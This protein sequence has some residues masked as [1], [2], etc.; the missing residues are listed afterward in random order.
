MRVFI[1]STHLDLKEYRAAAIRIL[2]NLN[3]EAIVGDDLVDSKY[4]PSEIVDICTKRAS[5]VDKLVLIIGIRQGWVPQQNEHGD[6]ENSI[7]LLEFIS[8][9]QSVG[10]DNLAIFVID[11]DYKVLLGQ[12]HDKPFPVSKEIEL[13]SEHV[14]SYFTN[15][16]DFSSRLFRLII[17][18]KL[19][20]SSQK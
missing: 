4:T 8:G 17:N 15:V 16:G 19:S 5:E 10:L 6:G 18:W 11:A 1:A 13:R 14:V 3:C 20:S 9:R 2:E 12:S 7:T